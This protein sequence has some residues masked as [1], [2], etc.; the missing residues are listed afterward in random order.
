[1]LARLGY[2]AWAPDMRGYGASSRPARVRGL[3]VPR[4]DFGDAGHRERPKG[5]VVASYLRREAAPSN[6]KDVAA[7]AAL[8][9][10]RWCYSAHWWRYRLAAWPRP[11]L[12]VDVAGEPGRRRG[13]A[14]QSHL[15]TRR[16][17]AWRAPDPAPGLQ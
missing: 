5:L 2:R 7:A 1:M 4:F 12:R 10:N 8:S 17:P 16:R 6:H 11:L 9:D 3:R 15:R 14:R 13:R